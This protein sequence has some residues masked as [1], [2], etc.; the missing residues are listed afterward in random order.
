MSAVVS[1]LRKRMIED[2][3]LHGL[4]KNTQKLYVQAVSQLSR[5]IQ[6]SPDKVT[7][8]DIRRYFLYLANE[9]KAAHS[10][11]SVALSG[12]KFFYQNTLRR[13]WPTLRLVRP[14][15]EHKLPVVLMLF[16]NLPEH[17]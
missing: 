15:Y 17:L 4:S 9:K 13:D 6:R 5:Y 8:E 1:P 7:E 16:D 12:I 3:Q 11:T 2:M 10:S 14:A